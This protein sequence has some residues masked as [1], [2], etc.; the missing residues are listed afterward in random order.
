M[1][2][3]PGFSP[4]PIKKARHLPARLR[5]EDEDDDEYEND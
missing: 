5:I 2:T 3:M 4:I 1:F